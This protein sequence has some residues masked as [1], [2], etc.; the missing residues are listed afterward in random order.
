MH[1]SHAC[2]NSIACSDANANLIDRD[3]TEKPDGAAFAFRLQQRNDLLT[4]LIAKQLA[5]M[6]FMKTDSVLLHQ[7]NKTAGRIDSQGFTRKARLRR[8][9]SLVLTGVDIGEVA[10]TS[11]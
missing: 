2:N 10:A 6:L 4:R 11:P 9:K 7:I 1:Q 8:H 3:R 5:A